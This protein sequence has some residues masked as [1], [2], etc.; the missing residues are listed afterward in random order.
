MHNDIFVYCILHFEIIIKA[1]LKCNKIF[2]LIKF[3]FMNSPN[4]SPLGT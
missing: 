1:I 4:D 3:I 2:V